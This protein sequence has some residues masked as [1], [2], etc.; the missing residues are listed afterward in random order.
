VTNSLEVLR[1]PWVF[2][3]SHPQTTSDARV[4]G[5]ELDPPTLR[6]LYHRSD[7]SLIVQITSR[8]V[9]DDI[10]VSE[11]PSPSGTGQRQLQQV[12]TEGRVRDPGLEP[13]R[14]RLR[15]DRC[16]TTDP[17]G[18]VR[19]PSTP[20]PVDGWTGFKAGNLHVLGVSGSYG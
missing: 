20:L 6:E 3:Q 15:F 19:T 11:V 4:R 10:E 9:R 5:V 12:L 8:R 14:P 17:H 18:S 16:K 1:L 2:S 13:Y 7:L